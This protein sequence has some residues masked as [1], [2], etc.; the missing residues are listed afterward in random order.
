VNLD[1]ADATQLPNRSGHRDLT[2]RRR[3]G[4]RWARRAGAVAL[5]FLLVVAG[6]NLWVLSQASG[7]LHPPESP[8]MPQSPVALVLGTSPRRANGAP[9][10]HFQNRMEAAAALFAA[11]KVNTLVV[12]GATD[13]RYYD[14][15]RDMRAYLIA[16]GVPRDA[17]IEDR[18]GVRTFDSV[19]R[20]KEH[21]HATHCAIISDAWHVPRAL[22][23]ADRIGLHAVG[24]RARPVPWR[25]SLKARSREWLARVLVVLDLYVL[26]TRPQND[27]SAG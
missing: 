3:A 16:H 14:E 5:T 2:G 17:I 26:G 4:S 11:G 8:L 27:G 24:V 12:S 20:L 22:F 19:V 18:E 15:P 1:S 10:R 25:Q 13:G 9:N 7:R 23:I 6:L 21:F